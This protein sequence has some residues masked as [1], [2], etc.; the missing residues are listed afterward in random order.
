MNEEDR[1]SVEEL[2]SKVGQLARDQLTD[3]DLLR[4]LQGYE[5]KTDQVVS[6]I[7]RNCEVLRAVDICNYE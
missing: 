3:F 1:R 6:L 4:W 2:R 5:Y 7:N